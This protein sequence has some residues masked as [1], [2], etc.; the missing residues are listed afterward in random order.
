MIIV[1]KYIAIAVM[2]GTLFTMF[3]W[4]EKPNLCKCYMKKRDEAMKELV[5]FAK[6]Y[7]FNIENY[8]TTWWR[9]DIDE[10]K[11]MGLFEG[12]DDEKEKQ[13]ESYHDGSNVGLLIEQII[14]K[15]K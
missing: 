13:K 14:N 15:K 9:A 1:L 2:P 6:K 5:E 10:A 8:M 12:N 4:H 11:D 7:G 3:D